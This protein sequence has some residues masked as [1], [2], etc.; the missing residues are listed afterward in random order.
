MVVAMATPRRLNRDQFFALIAEMDPADLRK[1][2]WTLYWRGGA[3]VRERIED[4]IEPDRVKV[5]T[6][7]VN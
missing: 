5:R 6:E 2:L 7:A 4:L 3:P 1:A